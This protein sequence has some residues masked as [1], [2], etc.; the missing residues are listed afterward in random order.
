MSLRVSRTDNKYCRT[1]KYVKSFTIP[2]IQ[3][4]L[5]A[6]SIISNLQLKHTPLDDELHSNVSQNQTM[7]SFKKK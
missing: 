1:P 4:C 7:I 2:M 6:T 3:Y 5:L